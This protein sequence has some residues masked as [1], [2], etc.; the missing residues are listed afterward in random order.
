VQTGRNAG[1][2]AAI[3]AGLAA[4]DPYDAV[5]VLNPGHPA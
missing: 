1:Y 5:L 4:A 2:A 3:N